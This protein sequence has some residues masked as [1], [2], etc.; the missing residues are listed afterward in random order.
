MDL[1]GTNILVTGGAGF[2]GSHVCPL[3][4]KK[5][6]DVAVVDDLSVGSENNVPDDV[7]LIDQDIRES[8]TVDTVQEVNP[9]VV[10]HLAAIHYVPYCSDNPGEAHGTNVVGTR[11]VLEG[12]RQA[13]VSK[14][15]F[16]SSAAVYP[17]R[18]GSNSEES[19]LEPIDVYGETKLLGEDLCRL[20]AADTGTPTIAARLFNIFGTNE[21][22]PHLIPAIVDQVQSGNEVELGNLTPKRD[23]VFVTDV[24]EALERMIV[25]EPVTTYRPYNVGTGQSRSVKEVFET[26]RD[27]MGRDIELVQDENRMRESDRPNLEADTSRIRSELGWK[28]SVPFEDGIRQVLTAQGIETD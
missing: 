23:F 6:G 17:P 24:A 28:P 16:A 20:F 12:A 14:V 19:E 1:N 4:I 11:H 25:E 26:V 10:L 9:N 22:N 15:V 8:H 27:L 21:T 5:G 2:V 13:N 3:L 18:E 7:Q